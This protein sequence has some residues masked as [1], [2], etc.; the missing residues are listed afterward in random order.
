MPIY[1]YICSKCSEM[2]SVLKLSTSDEK[3]RC[4]AC[5]S[6]DVVKRMSSFSCTLPTG[7]GGGAFRGGG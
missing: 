5:G 7:E 6:E 4:P 1:E 3:T 2:F